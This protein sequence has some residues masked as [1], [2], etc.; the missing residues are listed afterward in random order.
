MTL[1]TPP[2]PHPPPKTHPQSV[3]RDALTEDLQ[4]AYWTS[5]YHL[6]P[7]ARAAG[8]AAGAATGGGDDEPLRADVPTFLEGVA[9]EVLK[10]GK[11]LNVIR[12]CGQPVESPLDPGAR[13]AWD[14]GGAFVP[15][16]QAA[17]QRAAAALLAVM[18]GGEGQLLGWLR[19]MKHFFL[20][21]QA[22]AGGGR[23]GFAVS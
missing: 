9:L 23:G 6:R 3:G 20:L 12:E 14:A 15:L 5:R 10:T 16:I 11:Y 18:R 8:S 7:A 21:D 22:R 17:H 19:S 1:L 13:V 2:P 4:P